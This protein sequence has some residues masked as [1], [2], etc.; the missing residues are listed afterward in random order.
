MISLDNLHRVSSAITNILEIAA[1]QVPNVQVSEILPESVATA[2]V[3]SEDVKSCNSHGRNL[4]VP[5]ISLG[6][7][8]TPVKIHDQRSFRIRIPQQPTLN[9]PP[10]KA[11]VVMILNPN[12]LRDRTWRNEIDNNTVFESLQEWRLKEAVRH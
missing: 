9:P 1:A 5:P 7:C 12:V 11:L 6:C 2:E 8:R 4:W 3:G 10:I